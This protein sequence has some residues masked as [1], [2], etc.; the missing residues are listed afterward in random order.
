ML[1]QY[2][3]FT[4]RPKWSKM[5]I[6]KILKYH[7]ED[8]SMMKKMVGIVAGLICSVGL[9]VGGS[10]NTYAAEQQ[11]R[12]SDGND[13]YETA[14]YLDVN[15]SVTDII[16]DNIDK[17]FFRLNANENGAISIN[18][19]HTYKDS[20]SFWK[21]SVY[22]YANGEYNILSSRKIKLSDNENIEL[23]FV[24]ATRGS[25]YYIK[26][27][28]ADSSGFWSSI[29]ENYTLSSTFISSQ[30]YE[31]ENNDSYGMAN[32][33]LF[34]QTYQGVINNDNDEDFWKITA[35][36][37]GM[38][39]I[40][41]GHAYQDSSDGWNAYVYEYANGEYKELCSTTIRFND[42]RS[43]KFANIPVRK[44][45]IYYVKIKNNWGA[46][47]ENY[48]LKIKYVA[49]KPGYL[50]GNTNKR[51][52]TLY[53]ESVNGADGYE[54]YCKKAKGASYKKIADTKVGRY[55]YKKLS[56]K[57]YTYFKVRSYVMNGNK[58]TYSKFSY[59]VKLKA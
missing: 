35:S 24:G 5:R 45:G 43:L 17:D 30:Y 40:Y 29:D 25:A 36:K 7:E 41:F 22:Q 4:F 16:S 44:N 47:G 39:G 33:I 13:S 23:P 10:L 55:T 53:W 46:T 34:D 37:S 48:Q 49:E 57:A 51:S 31:Q 8:T 59:V 1:D 9:L 20:A 19:Q 42:K 26:V 52:A 21:V 2:G 54:I 6:D 32:N 58:K 27:E 28:G 11:E 38:M 12:V 3:L 18:F 15:G 14:R 50:I 56:K